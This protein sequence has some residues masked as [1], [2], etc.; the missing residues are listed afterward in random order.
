M[1]N[2]RTGFTI[3][4]LLIVIVVIAI[5]AT[6]SIVAYNG[7]QTRAKQAAQQAAAT[8]TER[9]IMTYALQ[10]NGESISLGGSLIGYQEG[11]GDV[12]FLKPLAGTPDV[13]MYMVYSV[14]GISSNYPALVYLAPS[15]PG[16]QVFVMN[17]GAANTSQMNSRI[18][19]TAS[20]NIT[21]PKSGTRIVGGTVIG[22][23]QVSEGLT[24]RSYG[25]NQSS[26][27]STNTI[28]PVLVGVLL[29]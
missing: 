7:V 29:A 10:A 5:L 13:T 22:W 1:L 6:I 18:D 8:Q 14:T 17:G 25:Y 21:G 27:E 3:V 15:V 24:K 9:S 19:T 12:G 28:S 26:A 4:E 2:K 20:Y 11:N 23:L 16:T